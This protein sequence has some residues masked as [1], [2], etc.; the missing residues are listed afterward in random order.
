MVKKRE[1][2]LGVNSFNKPAVANG[3]E[4]TCILLMELILLEPGSNPLKPLMGV[5]IKN[6]RYAHNK[7][8][9][10]IKRIK[11]QINDYL[12]E[13]NSCD[14]EIEE[15]TAAKVANIKITIDG[16]TYIYDSLSA[17]IPITL[18]DFKM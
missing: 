3:P 11:S 4:A 13:C 2:L 9:E 7:T 6:Y 5:G 12:P 1:Y 8:D 15:I 17:P 18:E 14:V 10:L 16:I